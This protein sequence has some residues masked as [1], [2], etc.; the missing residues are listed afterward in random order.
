ML[1]TLTFCFKNKDNDPQG[2]YF[3]KAYAVCDKHTFNISQRILIL[4]QTYVCIL[5]MTFH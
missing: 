5:L 2:F 4:C 3:M 1:K